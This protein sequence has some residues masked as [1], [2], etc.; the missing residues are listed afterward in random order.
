[1][2]EKERKGDTRRWFEEGRGE[3]EHGTERKKKL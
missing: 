1:M 2:K 3:E